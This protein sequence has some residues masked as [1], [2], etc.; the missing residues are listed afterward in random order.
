MPNTENIQQN[1]FD[2]ST[3]SLPVLELINLTKNYGGLIAV[4]NVNLSLPAGRII[5]LLGPNGSGKTTIIKLISGLLVPTSGEIRVN[6]F[7][8]GVESKAMVS[9]LPERNYLDNRVKVIEAIKMFE[10]FY[11]DFHTERA[12]DMLN[13]LGIDPNVRFKNMSKGTKEKVQLILVMS[14]RARLYLLDEPIGGVDPAARDYILDT[15]ITNYSPDSTV[16]LST[17]LIQDIE[18]VLDDVVF[19][20]NGIVTMHSSVDYIRTNQGKSV[21]QLFREVFRC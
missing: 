4:N 16:V 10:E 1:A 2:T 3:E 18:R 15:I 9:Y 8:P 5:G 14:R 7:Q 19:I 20:N 6:G 11:A 12:F 21:D 17:H 13:N